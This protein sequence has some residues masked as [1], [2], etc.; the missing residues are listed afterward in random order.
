MHVFEIRLLENPL[1]SVIENLP[2]DLHMEVINL[3]S[4]YIFKDKFK[5]ENWSNST[6]AFHMTNMFA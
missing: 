6:N 3:Q 5:E 1:D 4:N 2:S